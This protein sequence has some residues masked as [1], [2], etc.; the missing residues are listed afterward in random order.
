MIETVVSAPAVAAVAV[1]AAERVP[2]VRVQPGVA[3]LAGSLVRTARQQVKGLRPARA[4]GVRVRWS[5]GDAVLEVDVVVSGLDQAA[6]VAAA[7][8]RSVRSVVP[9]LTGVEVESVLVTVV[10]VAW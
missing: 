2:G 7:V 4:E 8:Q 3:G 5:G 10:D 1:H 9:E 6:A